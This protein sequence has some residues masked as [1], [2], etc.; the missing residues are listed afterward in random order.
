M[1]E[2]S[3]VKH[4]KALSLGLSMLTVVGCSHT[5]TE[6]AVSESPSQV[7]NVIMM[8][9]DGMGPQ[10][11]GLL[12]NYA[13][14]AST[15]IY[16]DQQTGL[17][18]M[19]NNGTLGLSSH[20]PADSIVADSA[21]SASQLATGEP[22][23]SEAVGLDINGNSVETVLELAKAQGKA[24]GLVSD[25]RLTHATPAAFAAHRYHR[26]LENQIAEDMLANQVDVMLSGG[27]RYWIPQEVN[28]KGEAYQAL[29]EKTGGAV[30]IKSKRKDN[31]NLLNEAE[32]MGYSLA[33]NRDD[34]SQVDNG[35]LL[36]L[37][38]YSGMQD[39]IEYTQTK[40]DPNRTMPGLREMTEKA[41][42]ILSQDEDGFFLMIEGGR[43]DWAGHDNDAGTMLHEMLKFD[44]AVN[45]V[46][47]WARK[48][49]DTLVLV[50]A[51][52]ETGGFGFSYTR[53]NLPEAKEVTGKAF[54][55][56][57]YKPNFNFGSFDILDK[58]YMQKKSFANI[59][60]DY[61]SGEKTAEALAKLV[62]ENSEFD[63]TVDQANEI[64]A[65][66]NNDYHVK[67]HKYLDSKSFPKVND[68]KSF[69][70]YGDEIR[71]DLLGRALSEQ[72][73]VVWGTGT[74]TSTPVAV[75]AFGPDAVE[76][77]FSSMTHHIELGKMAKKAIA[78]E[79]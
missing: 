21:C 72:Q 74:H 28:E 49:N 63:I 30:K 14:N 53:A 13:V 59:L 23:L 60:A 70:V 68:F 26:S 18:K 42:D 55:N 67:G 52:H 56:A 58:L 25:T 62:N 54:A 47:E 22:S 7:K 9:G 27:L 15:S 39:G 11:M 4:V 45:Y 46:Y 75:I 3:L 12:E 65:R 71:N 16:K 19:I 61:D 29:V 51:D 1:Q 57:Q 41:L 5:Q 20:N 24:T 2:K 73:N 44:E 32:K 33:F 50:T 10:Q 76:S 17:A 35:K 78:G 6:S 31:K 36:G 43:I 79:I 66:E 38:A 40:N 37:F 77:K 64:L 69:Y 8:I 34:L 48:R